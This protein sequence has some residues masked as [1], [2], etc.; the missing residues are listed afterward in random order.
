MT[1]VS[2]PAVLLRAHDYGDSSRILR[3]YTRAHGL[4]SVVA[5]GV[6]G[7]MG[8]GAAGVASFA[9]GE[10][11][12]YV[13]THRDLHTMRDFTCRRMREGLGRD[14]LRFAGA[15]AVA[16]LVLAHTEQESHEE[17]YRTLESALDRLEQVDQADLPSA[18]LAGLWTVTEALGFA[19]QVEAC[20]R[21]G[22]VL[23]EGD[24]GRFD[25]AAGGVRCPSCA[26]GAAGPRIGPVA[27]SQVAALLE[28][29]S[30]EALTHCRQ[31]LGLVCD[32]IAYHVASKPLKSFRFLGSLLPEDAVAAERP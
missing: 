6:R 25:L 16:E 31:H 23:G 11:T 22:S 2:T 17:L 28:G 24:V 19:P 5:K 8:K 29:G 7:R 9:S 32:F 1:P 15:S 14:M 26:E 13:R 27:R 21:C 3:F 12:A 4:V 30:P 18:V 20:I 10:L